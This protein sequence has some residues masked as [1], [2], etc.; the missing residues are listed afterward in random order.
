MNKLEV[1]K[2]R[3]RNIGEQIGAIEDAARRDTN[4]KKVGKFYKTRNNYSV[5]SKPSDYWWLYECVT[6]MDDGG[7]LWTMAFQ[8]DKNGTISIEPERYAYHM[9][10]GTEITKAEFDR[11]WMRLK[12]NIIELDRS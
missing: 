12:A 7:F 11:A 10:Y 4:G 6:R 2:A 8:T 9:Q 1:L 5:P 3:A